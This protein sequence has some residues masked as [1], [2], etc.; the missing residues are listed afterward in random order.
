MKKSL[1]S[2]KK[3]A[4]QVVLLCS[5]L[6]GLSSNVF[7]FTVYFDNTNTNWSNV[8]VY[9]YSEKY[10]EG[11]GSGSKSGKNCKLEDKISI[12]KL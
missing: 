12:Q 2:L 10:W 5:M 11:N 4:L 9:F 1:L 3:C 6:F 7:G 8:Y